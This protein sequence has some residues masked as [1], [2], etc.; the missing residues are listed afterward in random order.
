M[1]GWISACW[2]FGLERGRQHAQVC[3]VWW[4]IVEFWT[5][6]GVRYVAATE[7]VCLRRVVKGEAVVQCY[8][9]AAS[10]LI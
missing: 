4:C 10:G 2:S 8:T 7:V 9:V 3:L 1:T 5:G 6:D